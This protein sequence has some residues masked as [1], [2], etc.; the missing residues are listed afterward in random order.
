TQSQCD[1]IGSYDW[2]YQAEEDPAN[3]SLMVIPSSSSFDNETVEFRKSR[4]DVLSYQAALEYVESRFVVY[5]Q[6]ESIFQENIIVLKMRLSP[7]GGYH[8]VP[9]PITGNFMP[10]KPDLVF[11]TAPLAVESDHSAF[12]VQPIEVP[13]LAATPKPTIKTRSSGKRKN[14]KTCFVCRNVDHLIKD[15]NFHVK[16]QT[17]PTPRN[18]A[19]RG[20]N[21]QYASLTKKYPQKHKVP[22]AVLPKSKPVSVTA[23]RQVSA[24]VPKI[25]KSRPRPAHPLN[26]KCNL[27]IR[28]YKSHNQFSKTSN[29]SSKVIAAKVSVVSAVKG[30]KGKWVWRPKCPILDHDL[31][32]TGASLT[33]KR[34]DY[35]DALGRSKSV[36]AWVPTRI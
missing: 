23:V 28:R 12:N 18:S 3:F 36:M 34:F 19:H 21:K 24:A 6:N 22:A 35:N 13:I 7:S 29:L 9:P 25:M 5:K 16:P 10:P 30:K 33:L 15:C 20:C 26:R 14:R 2:S 27:Y 4:L 31:R 8:A 1:G 11:N 32:T 17:K